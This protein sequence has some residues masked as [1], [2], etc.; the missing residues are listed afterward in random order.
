MLFTKHIVRCCEQY[1][2]FEQ[3][4]FVKK[5]WTQYRYDIE[6]CH[7]W[8]QPFDEAKC[9]VNHDL[10]RWIRWVNL[11]ICLNLGSEYNSQSLGV[12]LRIATGLLNKIESL[13]DEEKIQLHS[14]LVRNIHDEINKIIDETLPF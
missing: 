3:Y 11:N 4:N 8:V 9:F 13:T 14:N 2:L 12:K 10:R 5:I 1:Y 6:Q 7:S